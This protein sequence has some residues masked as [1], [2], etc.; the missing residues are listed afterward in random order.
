MAKAVERSEASKLKVIKEAQ[1]R[2]QRVLTYE[3]VAR[4]RFVDDVK[5]AE[6]D[7][8]NNWQWPDDIREPRELDDRPMLTINKTRQHILDVLNDARQ[9]KV[10][11]KIVATGGAA[12]YE[13]AQAYMGV[14]RAIEYRSNADSAYQ[15]ALKMSV[16]GGIGYWRL[17]TDFVDDDTFD[18]EILIK[19]VKNPLLVFMD[20]DI[21][22]FD[23]SDQNWCFV[24]DEVPKDE[25]ERRYPKWKGRVKNSILGDSSWVMDGT[26]RIAEYW[27]RSPTKDTLVA[28]LN[29]DSGLKTISRLSEIPKAAR[30]VIMADEH[31]IT[32]PITSWKVECFKIIGDEIAEENEWPGI[33]IPIVRCVGEETVIEGKMDRKG[34]TRALKDAQRM[35]N[36]NASAFVEHGALQTK[37]PYVGAAEAFEDYE[38]DWAQANKRNFAFLTFNGFMEDGVTAIPRPER[39]APPQGAPLYLEGMQNAAEWMRM[40]SGQ[41]Q[42]DMGAPSNERSGVAIQQRQR[43]GD[44]ATYHYLD[45]QASA[46]RFTGKILIDLIPKLYDT[47]RVLRYKGED[48]V[49][50]EVHIDPRT[51][52]AAGEPPL[53][54]VRTEPGEDRD[55]EKTIFNPNVGKYDVEADV[56]PSFATKRQDAFNAY[57]QILAQNKELTSLIGDL[58]LQF[59]DFPGADEAARRLKRMVPAQALDEKANPEVDGLKQ[60]IAEMSQFVQVLSKKLEDKSVDQRKDQEKNSIT[61]YDSITKRIVALKEALATEPARLIRLVQEVLDEGIATSGDGSLHEALD[62]PVAEELHP[63]VG[64][65]SPGPEPHPPALDPNAAPAGA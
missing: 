27:R 40:V 53:Q 37:V 46:I 21:N 41:Y 16:Q 11:V 34:H 58:A 39:Q 28:W 60:Q 33:Y 22:E 19:R 63:A 25:F 26:V 56:G 6:G 49:E 52:A 7:S 2:F 13:S 59:A 47:E 30:A 18:Q 24:A 57:T 35:F 29:P 12:T 17:L 43:Q 61:A 48:G 54:A 38:D 15:H 3:G 45:H 64:G 32:R 65:L 10:G 50:Q 20:P 4:K 14:V 9:S 23:G 55:S 62:V 36:Y 42:A 8:D 1:G 5:F 31:T 51:K 44:N